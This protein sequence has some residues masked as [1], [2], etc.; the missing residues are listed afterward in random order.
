MQI[1]AVSGKHRSGAK[2]AVSRFVCPGMLFAVVFLFSITFPLDASP[3]RWHPE[4]LDYSSRNGLPSSM[5]FRVLQDRQ[6]YIWLGT[7]HGA[8]R[9]DGH[10]FRSYTTR[11]GLLD[12]T[13]IDIAEDGQGRLWFLT[14]SR[15]ICYYA[16]GQI[17]SLPCNDLLEKRLLQRP[18]K[19]FFG[20]D[21]SI[22]LTPLQRDKL[23]VC[24]GDTVQEVRWQGD[25][26]LGSANYYV[27]K[28]G[29]DWVTVTTMESPARDSIVLTASA[30]DRYALALPENTQGTFYSSMR[31]EDGRIL[32]WD[33]FRFLL[34]ERDGTVVTV[35]NS[36]EGNFNS[37]TVDGAGDIW[38]ITKNGAFR[39][40]GGR[41]RNKAPEHFLPGEFL[42]SVL[43]DRAGSYWFASWNHGLFHV[44]DARFRTLRFEG[45]AS[46][47]AFSSLRVYDNRL[48]FLNT[49]GS[50]FTL[51]DRN[52][53]QE[54][55]N[56]EKV[57]GPNPESADFLRDRNGRFWVGQN[58][59]QVT[60]EKY[61]THRVAKMPIAAAKV[62][63]PLRS[64]AVAV[65]TAN[66]VQI[67]DTSYSSFFSLNE[68]A[69]RFVERTNALCETADGTLWIGA[70][71][72]LYRYS[73]GILHYEGGENT[74][75]Q[76]RVVGLAVSAGGML[77]LATRGAGV[78]LKHGD[79]VYQI[80]SD[81]GLTSDIV[82]SVFVDRDGTIWAGTNAGLNRIIV[83]SISPLE[84]DILTWSIDKGLPS[85]GIN[86]IIRHGENIWLAT[87]DGLCRFNPDQVA[88]NHLPLPIYITGLTVNGRLV[89][90][91][92][93]YELAWDQNNLALGFIGLGFRTF[94][95]IR[96]RYRLLGLGT[97][98]L[99]HETVNRTIPFFSLAPGSYVFQ[100]SAANEDGIWNPVP[101]ELRFRIAPHFTQT[102]WFLSGSVLLGLLVLG[103]VVWGVLRRVHRQNAVA[104]QISELRHHALRANMNPHFISNSLSV[105][106]DYVMH[107]DP[108]EANTF[109]TR[110]NRLIRLTL[111]ISQNSFVSLGAEL[112]RLELYLSLERLRFG[113]NLEYTISITGVDPDETPVPSM[114]IQPYVENAIWHG[115]LPSGRHGKI[116]IN[117]ATDGPQRYTITIQDN[118][119]GLASAQSRK[120]RGRTS[121]SMAH[122][123]ERL[124]LLSRSL[125][126]PFSVS[127]SDGGDASEGACGTTVVI[128][129]P[130]ELCDI[131][132]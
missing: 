75:L 23:Y 34:V 132:F 50:I 71:S 89:S 64:G 130:S 19:I 55:I 18:S 118:G 36:P 31:L 131:D 49:S 97:D 125:R 79:D 43:R 74:L 116:L 107:H 76:N 30:D 100:V 119:V 61:G 40:S 122:N 63:L 1:H 96:Y 66:G 26:L 4:V 94:Q 117:I 37:V 85:N 87:D 67:F 60:A 45:A 6:G 77:V 20:D 24:R 111:E 73:D 124:H 38:L 109:L 68:G 15:K 78:L 121:F 11:D 62:F 103:G 126:T 95:D 41:L 106:Q 123:R 32:V 108:V 54:I 58:V 110:F 46:D 7:N 102:F 28:L 88:R 69:V 16:D 13:V 104:M 114:L 91:D 25:P 98:T 29:R 21:G 81:A 47:N 53:P 42:T 48:W 35:R 92:Q 115:I 120:R 10:T 129:L 8:L 105:I 52:V 9:Y 99:W 82:R 127:V 22:W 3:F 113:E 51:K 39:Y 128:S 101:E 84:T 33:N 12:N 2:T 57:L 27:R 86:S 112:E 56:G 80:N 70:L 14:L 83:R 5:I 72:G 90:R 17:H 44:P 93:G 65:G 59:R